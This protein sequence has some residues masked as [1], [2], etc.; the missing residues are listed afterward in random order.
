MR[1][2][3]ELF[4]RSTRPPRISRLLPRYSPI[5]IH[6]DN[7]YGTQTGSQSIVSIRL[8]LLRTS[9]YRACPSAIQRA[10]HFAR[11]ITDYNRDWTVAGVNVITVQTRVYDDHPAGRTIKRRRRAW[12]LANAE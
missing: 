11:G 5:I 4:S 3:P 12:K 9:H 2:P 8:F 7:L 1:A 6:Y 10:K